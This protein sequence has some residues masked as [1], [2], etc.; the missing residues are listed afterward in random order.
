MPVGNIRSEIHKKNGGRGAKKDALTVAT[1]PGI[2]D[3]RK[4]SGRKK[5]RELRHPSPCHGW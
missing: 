4:G 3:K 1:D 5:A 2:W